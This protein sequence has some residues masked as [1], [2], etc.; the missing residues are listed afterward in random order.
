M[1]TFQDRFKQTIGER[2]YETSMRRSIQTVIL[3]EAHRCIANRLPSMRP[4]QRKL[5]FFDQVQALVDATGFMPHQR[6]EIMWRTGTS[7]EAMNAETAWKRLK[8][9]EKEIEKLQEKIK[10]LCED[11]RGHDE[12]MNSFVQ[13]QFVSANSSCL[14]CIRCTL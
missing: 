12:I 11:G 6:Q 14:F 5:A 8:L 7:K 10:P 13:Q 4:F 1:A 3:Y 9:I 2:G